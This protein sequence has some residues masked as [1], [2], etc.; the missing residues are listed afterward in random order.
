MFYYVLC[1]Y[2][3]MGSYVLSGPIDISP[4]MVVH[5]Q[6]CFTL[7]SVIQFRFCNLINLIST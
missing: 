6:L 3:K 2:K 1:L 4:K 5:R 7:D